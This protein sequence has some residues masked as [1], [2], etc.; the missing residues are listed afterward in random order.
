MQLALLPAILYTT[1]FIFQ[2]K[3]LA[4]K[5]AYL[6]ASFSMTILAF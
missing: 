1:S 4:A 3:P 2:T 6:H 5:L